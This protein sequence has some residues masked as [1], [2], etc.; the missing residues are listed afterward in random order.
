MDRRS[1]LTAFGALCAWQ[2]PLPVRAQAPMAG[3]LFRIGF[4]TP[5]PSTESRRVFL[6]AMSKF[7]W[8]EGT[9]FVVIEST[10]AYDQLRANEAIDAVMLQNPDLIYCVSTAQALV[11]HRRTKSIPIVMLFSGYPVE[12]G[13]AMSLSRPGKNVT[14]N[15][16]YAGTGVWGKLLELLRE[17]KPETRTISVLWAY[18]PPAFAQPETDVAVKEMQTVARALGVTL[19][20]LEVPTPDRLPATFKE[21]V[22]RRSDA[23]VVTGGLMAWSGWTEVMKFAQERRLPTVSDWIQFPNDTR[24][25]PLMAYGPSITE[26][27]RQ[28]HSYI[29]R[30]MRGAKA[31]DLPIQQ[32]SRFEL[33]VDLRTAK[34]S[35]L[36]VPQSLLLRTDRVIE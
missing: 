25:R 14:G 36:K 3:R 5:F 8:K 2:V 6:D 24:S 16:A 32:P 18:G 20:F 27:V 29:D 30:I 13:L 9:D 23:L 11:A 28:A 21:V 10:V 12:A 7:G 19:Q 26:L 4:A 34:A 22:A 35:G 17:C 33:V 15:T 1:L 31:G